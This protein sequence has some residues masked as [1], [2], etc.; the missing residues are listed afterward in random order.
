MKGVNVLFDKTRIAAKALQNAQDECQRRK[1]QS[2]QRIVAML[3][4]FAICICILSAVFVAN[5]SLPGNDNITIDPMA[6]PLAAPTA[7][8]QTVTDSHSCPVCGNEVIKTD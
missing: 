4:M 6:V 5:M 2:S 1:K 8:I 7:D 3:S